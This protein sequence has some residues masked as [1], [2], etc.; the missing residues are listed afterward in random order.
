[1][2]S[3]NIVR[4]LYCNKNLNM[5][6]AHECIQEFADKNSKPL[7]LRRAVVRVTIMWE[8]DVVFK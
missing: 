5:D 7:K 6:E 1:M 3:K 4:C 2:T 8:D